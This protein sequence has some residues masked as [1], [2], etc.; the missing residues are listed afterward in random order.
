M[1]GAGPALVMEAAT[2]AVG[3]GTD[4]GSFFTSRIVEPLVNHS[5]IPSNH[6]HQ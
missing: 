5:V 6:H 1:A 3:D 2:Y 4:P